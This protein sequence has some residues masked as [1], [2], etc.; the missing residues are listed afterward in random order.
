MT[1]RFPPPWTVKKADGGFKV[2]DADRLAVAY[3]YCRDTAESASVAK[4]LP[5]R[6]AAHRCE[7]REAA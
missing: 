6:G 2:V 3:T 5:G 4:V 7:H 1:R